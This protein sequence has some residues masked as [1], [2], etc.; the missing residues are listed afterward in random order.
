M[1]ITKIKKVGKDTYNVTFDNKRE[2]LL[3]E[4]IIIKN[5]LT[6]NKII[7]ENSFNKIKAEND[8]IK[9]YNQGI[10]YIGVRQ[11]S[12]KEIYNYLSNKNDNQLLVNKVIKRLKIEG[13]IDDL[14]F[15][16]A[17]IN[18][19][20]YL[21]SQGP[22]RI[23]RELQEHDIK[24]EII[25]G[26]INNI[27]KD[28]IK[29]KITKIINKQLKI[30]TKYNGMVLKKKI[31]FFL[32]NRGYDKEDII[33]ELDKIN[34]NDNEKLKK[35]YQKVVVQLSKKYTGYELKTRI[36]NKL[37]QKGFDVNEINNIML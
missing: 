33:K 22:Y 7:D 23:K 15:A 27:D 13:Y 10:K 18:D 8:E 9:V 35:E 2:Y 14:L 24:E 25:A 6:E 37:F 28:L 20:M 19:K 31:L 17:F 4:D 3:Y 1:E 29:D 12:E 5:L 26:L 21:S 32:I 30:Y 16:T 34:F 36:K 11:R